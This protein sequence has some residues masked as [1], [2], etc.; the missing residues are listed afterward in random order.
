[1]L[2]RAEAA[3]LPLWRNCLNFFIFIFVADDWNFVNMR[4]KVAFLI[5]NQ[6]N[7]CSKYYRELF[8][9]CC[10]LQ[11]YCLH[12]LRNS[13]LNVIAHFDRHKFQK[14][15]GEKIHKHKYRNHFLFA[16]YAC[17]TCQS[18]PHTHWSSL[19]VS[20]WLLSKAVHE[21]FVEHGNKFFLI[22]IEKFFGI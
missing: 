22:R 8:F 21:Q 7:K 20:V 4:I 5:T 17:S 9:R 14:Q 15:Y 2:T 13:N 11:K 16:M 10:S 12:S 18:L 6:L 3:I 19:N 1:M